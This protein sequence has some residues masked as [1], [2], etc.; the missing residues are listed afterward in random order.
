MMYGYAHALSIED[1]IAVGMV[2]C[3]S[4]P[5]GAVSN[6]FTFWSGGDLDLRQE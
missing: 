6:M 1:A 5:G 4:C 3:A 2:L